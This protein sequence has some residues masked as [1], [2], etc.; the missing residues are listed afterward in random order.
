MWDLDF[1]VL[2]GSADQSSETT[3]IRAPPLTNHIGDD[4]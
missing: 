3:P 2:L 1:E 4:A